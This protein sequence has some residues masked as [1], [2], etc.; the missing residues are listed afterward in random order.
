MALTDA[1]IEAR[2]LEVAKRRLLLAERTAVV[3][4][5]RDMI[6]G[7]IR[8]ELT[9]A[10]T[11]AMQLPAAPTNGRDDHDTTGPPPARALEAEALR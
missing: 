4:Q 3:E 2:K 1:Q 9:A 11:R 10:L 8:E 7:M 5:F 6:R